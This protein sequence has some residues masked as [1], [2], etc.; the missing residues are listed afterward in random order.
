MDR[1]RDKK[2]H[3]FWAV[4]APA[5]NAYRAGLRAA[6]ES[7]KGTT[8]PGRLGADV[9]PD[10]V[11]TPGAGAAA[12]GSGLAS[13]WLRSALL[14][15]PLQPHAVLASTSRVPTARRARSSTRTAR[16]SAAGGAGG[17]C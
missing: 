11:S 16:R 14:A 13:R 6:R 15:S 17:R 1:Q 3:A 10:E 4:Y 9:A 12:I 5:L 8:L 7:H 2:P